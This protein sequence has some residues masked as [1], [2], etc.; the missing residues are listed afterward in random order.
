MYKNTIIT[1]FVLSA[2]TSFAQVTKEPIH[3]HLLSHQTIGNRS[4]ENNKTY[5]TIGDSTFNSDQLTLTHPVG[6]SGLYVKNIGTVV[7]NEGINHS[8]IVEMELT[9]TDAKGNLADISLVQEAMDIE[10]RW[11]PDTKRLTILKSISSP[12]MIWFS[13]PVVHLQWTYA[14]GL[15]QNDRAFVEVQ[16]WFT[17]T[18]QEPIRQTSPQIPCDKRHTHFI[19]DCSQSMSDEDLSYISDQ[20]TQ[21]AKAVNMSEKI[22]VSGFS[23][24]SRL[25]IE[26]EKAGKISFDRL[27]NVLKTARS[28]TAGHTNWIAGL[29]STTGLQANQII[30]ITDGWH[31]GL[32]SRADRL[33]D[34]ITKIETIS[35]NLTN[36]AIVRCISLDELNRNNGW[37]ML[38]LISG[39]PDLADQGDRTNPYI[40]QDQKDKKW[41]V[42]FAELVTPC[43]DAAFAL[44]LRKTAKNDIELSWQP[45]MDIKSYIV[46]RKDREGQWQELTTVKGDP[47][48]GKYTTTDRNLDPD[49]YTYKVEA[50]TG[51]TRPT[52]NERLAEITGGMA[53][54]PNPADNFV[55]VRLQHANIDI[56]KIELINMFGARTNAPV[57]E[58]DPHTYR[59]D[60]GEL[61]SGTYILRYSDTATGDVCSGK[62][63]IL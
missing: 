43:S 51:K 28:V 6:I 40:Y 20:I 30:F 50:I 45:Y 48:D 54:Y 57:R 25:L 52:T 31:N 42:Q 23:G 14:G 35:G 32:T 13:K 55:V 49:I 22:S 15:G 7:V 21:W 37:R 5:W 58:V 18:R 60:T 59:I 46:Y 53:W 33:P 47:A 4:Y 9:A 2:L 56:H 39:S 8:P 27:Y 1:M 19:V 3:T 17:G 36:N 16:E 41:W 63:I 24:T 10:T 61:P 26:A 12:V 62:V 44:E 29:Q 38:E 34:E 11:N